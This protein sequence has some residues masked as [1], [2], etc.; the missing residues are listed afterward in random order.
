MAQM[1]VAEFRETQE[2]YRSEMSAPEKEVL[3]KCTEK[4]DKGRYASVLSAYDIGSTV[5]KAYEKLSNPEEA[6]SRIAVCLGLQNSNDPDAERDYLLQLRGVASCWQRT[7]II[8]LVNRAAELNTRLTITHLIKLKAITN[9]K[10]RNKMAMKVVEEGWSVSNIADNMDKKLVEKN[11]PLGRRPAKPKTKLAAVQQ[12]L[13]TFTTVRNKFDNWHEILLE[14]E[15]DQDECTL[16]FRNSLVEAKDM[17]VNVGN[18]SEIL[19]KELE[20]LIKHIDDDTHFHEEDELLQEV[21]EGEE[22]LETRKVRA[23]S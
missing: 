13:K 20:T 5:Q 4:R 10:E 8:T 21:A 7:E 9:E 22:E 12:L 11:K 23:L 19:G 2:R 18:R 6:I 17:I 3:Y 15:I 14:D 16:K 1:S